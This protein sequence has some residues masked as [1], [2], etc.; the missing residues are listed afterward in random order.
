MAERLDGAGRPTPPRDLRSVRA[1]ELAALRGWP[2][3]IQLKAPGGWVLRATPGLDRARSNH[4]LTPCRALAA[5]ELL[6]AI[7]AVRAFAHRHRIRPGMQVTPLGLH[8]ALENTLADQG[9]QRRWP[10]LVLARPAPDAGPSGTPPGGRPAPRP[11]DR[12]RPAAVAPQV[13]RHGDRAD[14]D[15]LDAWARCEPGRDVEAHA[16]TVLAALA[17]RACFGRLGDQA[18]GIAVPW[19]GT[20]GL[21][22]VAVDR[23]RRRQGLGRAITQALI[24]LHPGA[25]VFLQVESDNAAAIALYERLGLRATHRYVHWVAPEP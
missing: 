7:E 3:T 13:F 18:V 10:A 25:R 19:R 23:Q 17:G 21:Y 11:D 1:L 5:G 22:C 4:A 12:P 20:L 15:W 14:R 24:S 8:D 6:P 2:A 9:W 16:R